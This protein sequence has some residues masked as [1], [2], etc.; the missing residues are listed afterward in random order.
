MVISLA[1]LPISGSIHQN[2]LRETSKF[3]GSVEAI[4]R[5]CK[6]APYRECLEIFAPGLDF[7]S[8]ADKEWVLGKALAGVLD[9][10][11]PQPV[12]R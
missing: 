7:L 12:R 8:T 3:E 10:P 1:G 2:W 4:G 11:E 6:S 5:V 9:W